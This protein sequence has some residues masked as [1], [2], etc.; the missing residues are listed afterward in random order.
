[1][2]VRYNLV[3]GRANQIITDY[4]LAPPVDIIKLAEQQGFLVVNEDLEDWLSATCSKDE[5]IIMLNQNHHWHRRR[6]SL[7]HELGHFFLN[8]DQ[9]NK[10]FDEP[11]K[12]FK[13]SLEI[14]A[15]YFA[16]CVLMPEQ[17]FKAAFSKLGNVKEI[18]KFFEVSETAAWVR[19]KQ[20]HLI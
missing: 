6:F 16:G 19:I 20:L 10:P 2:G 5:M 18:S 11:Y 12:K 8:H 14:E 17:A 13:K 4:H 15:D 3:R 9:V 7:G 1:M